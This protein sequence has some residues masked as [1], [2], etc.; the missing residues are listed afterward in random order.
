MADIGPDMIPN[1]FS[2]DSVKWD[3]FAEI[4]NPY[5]VEQLARALIPTGAEAQARE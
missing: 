4:T 5:D 3:P 2:P 1:L